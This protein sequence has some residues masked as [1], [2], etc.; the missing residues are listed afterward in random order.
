MESLNKLPEANLKHIFHVL[1]LLNNT[2]FKN[3]I[4][5]VLFVCRYKYL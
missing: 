4:F 1:N 3:Y 2:Q 5:P